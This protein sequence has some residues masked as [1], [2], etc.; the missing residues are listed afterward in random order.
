[1]SQNS[2]KDSHGTLIKLIKDLKSLWKISL[3]MLMKQLK[4]YGFEKNY[5]VGANIAGFE[6]VDA[7]NA[8][9]IV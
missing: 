5:V 6:K 3:L 1:M 2:Q 8:Q 7:M 4:T 9:G